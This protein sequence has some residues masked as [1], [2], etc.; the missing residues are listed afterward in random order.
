METQ[1]VI[2]YSC[3]PVP[4]FPSEGYVR[5]RMSEIMTQVNDAMRNG[6]E[7]LGGIAIDASGNMFQVM[8][9]PKTF[10]QTISSGI[11]N[12]AALKGTGI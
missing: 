10:T 6:W 5:D 3:A 8:I 2:I 4:L 1:Y 11:K 12:S 7:P 9:K